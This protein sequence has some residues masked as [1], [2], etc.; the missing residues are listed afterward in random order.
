MATGGDRGSYAHK[1]ASPGEAVSGIQRVF[2][3]S[4]AAEPQCLVGAVA[5]RGEYLA[6]N[7]LIH[8]R[9]LGVAP[10]ASGYCS[11]GVSVDIVKAAAESATTVVAE[12][13]ANMPR[14]LGD[15][16]IHLDRIDMVSDGTSPIWWRWRGAGVWRVSPLMYWWR[17]H[18]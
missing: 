14:T 6:D 5:T 3:G 8:I 16:F 2:I 4:G 9:S 1:L 10:Y 7:Q 13:N 17:T 15:S 18:G 11:Y 12:V